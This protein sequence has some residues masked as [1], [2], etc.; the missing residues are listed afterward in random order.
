MHQGYGPKETQVAQNSTR[1]PIEHIIKQVEEIAWR[2]ANKKNEEF[3]IHL[4]SSWDE[5]DAG[6]FRPVQSNGNFDCLCPEL[7]AL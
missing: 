6:F 7:A 5:V 1:I 2:G 3:S 4:L